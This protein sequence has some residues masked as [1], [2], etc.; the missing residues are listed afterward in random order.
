MNVVDSFIDDVQ[1]AELNLFIVML[2]LIGQ[3]KNGFENGWEEAWTIVKIPIN[4]IIVNII[5][6]LINLFNIII[7]IF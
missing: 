4:R 2:I 7:S 5:I 3:S 6:I 1:L